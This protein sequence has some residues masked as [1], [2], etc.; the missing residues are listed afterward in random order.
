MCEMAATH[1]PTPLETAPL[2]QLPG[3]R[4]SKRRR[5]LLLPAFVT[6]NSDLRVSCPN[7]SV[8]GSISDVVS[9]QFGDYCLCSRSVLRS[10]ARL[11]NRVSVLRAQRHALSAPASAAPREADSVTCM[12]YRHGSKPNGA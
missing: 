6:E 12:Q 10:T 4:A 9:K 1:R 2:Q 3:G 8:D 5:A 11:S 7:A